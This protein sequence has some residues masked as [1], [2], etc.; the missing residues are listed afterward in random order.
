[1]ANTTVY[2]FGTD[3][4][5]PSSIAII[6]DLST[7]GADKALSA[8]MG[9]VL[10]DDT[11]RTRLLVGDG[12]ASDEEITTTWVQGTISWD[13]GSNVSSTVTL[14]SGFIG[15][16]KNHVIR[17]STAP[18][19]FIKGLLQYNTAALTD[20]DKVIYRGNASGSMDTSKTYLEAVSEGKFFRICFGKVDGSTITTSESGNL[21]IHDTYIALNGESL[22]DHI[23]DIEQDI[24]EINEIPTDVET[25]EPDVSDT[26]VATDG[27]LVGLTVTYKATSLLP[28]SEGDVFT[29]KGYTGSLAVP[30]AGYNAEGTFVRAL[31]TYGNYTSNMQTITIPSDISQVRFCG[32]IDSYILEIKKTVGASIPLKEGIAA[33]SSQ[34]SEITEMVTLPGKKLYFLGDSIPAGSVSSGTAPSKPYPVLVA[35]AMGMELT[36]YAIG[37]STIA[38]ADGNGGMFASLADLQAA[39]KVTGQYYTVLTGNQSY[40]VYYWNGSSLSTSTRKLRTPVSQRYALVGDDAD[41]IVVAA[42]TND[43]QYNWTSVGSMSDRTPDTFYGAMHT[44]CLGLLD[45]FFG[46]AIIFATPIKRAQTVQDT[47]ADTEAHKGGSYGLPDS[48]NLFGETLGDYA[49]I[50]KEVC[51]Y[52]SIPVVDLYAASMLNPSIAS[53]SSLFDSW[54]THPFQQG[55]DIIAR[56]FIG[57]IRSIIGKIIN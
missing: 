44:I 20:F 43:F 12:Q 35:E 3:G 30:C 52:Y 32:R 15:L 26:Y 28:V 7:G 40:Q 39:T 48:E 33:L 8:E 9:K 16:T 55:H 18:G 1:M 2:P 34:V 56:Y 29:Y 47:D 25:I 42:G 38:V 24:N 51:R 57:Q 4:T 17:I 6:N 10:G 5:L 37:G 41:V 19:Y 31:L 45:K 23:L 36:N 13:D 14:R 54:K 11:M 21:T 53:Q 46:K 49:E 27:S 50:I 22:V